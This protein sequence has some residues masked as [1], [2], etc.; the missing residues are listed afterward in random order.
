M[1]E[2]LDITPEQYFILYKL[3]IKDGVPQVQLADSAFGDFPN[4]TRILDG[5]EK[6]KLI[7]RQKDPKDRRKYLILLT[8]KGRSSMNELKKPILNERERLFGEFSQVELAAFLNA[9]NR[10]QNVLE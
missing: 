1:A 5:L 4:M 7:R 2:G 6:K 9:L 3:F 8:E 10:L